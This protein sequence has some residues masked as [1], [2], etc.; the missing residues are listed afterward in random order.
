MR[1]RA[2][3]LFWLALNVERVSDHGTLQNLPNDQVTLRE[4][5]ARIKAQRLAAKAQREREAAEATSKSS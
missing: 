2:R 3:F 1:V 5:L 4:E